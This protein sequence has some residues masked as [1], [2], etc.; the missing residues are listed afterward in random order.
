MEIGF[1]ILNYYYYYYIN[2]YQILDKVLLVSTVPIL[3]IIKRTLPPITKFKE[4][5]IFEWT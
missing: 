5:N 3:I 4:K 1:I 2:L